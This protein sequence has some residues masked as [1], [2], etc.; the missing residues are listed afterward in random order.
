[1]IKFKGWKTFTIAALT[2][3]VGGVATIN[4]PGDYRAWVILAA[5]ALMAGLRAITTTAP[6]R[7]E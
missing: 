6:G 7:S 4:D 1:M 5:G 3:I 2:V